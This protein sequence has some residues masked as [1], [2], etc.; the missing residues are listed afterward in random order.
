[1][2]P[3][4]GISPGVTMADVAK[5]SGVSLS[6]VSLVINQKPGISPET[7]N[8][9][10]SAAQSLGYQRKNISSDHKRDQSP[11]IQKLGV[12]VKSQI[13]DPIPPT[14]NVFY[15]HVLAGIEES[16][17]H[18]NLMLMLSSVRVDS[19]SFPLD[20]P[21]LLLNDFIDA[22]LLVGICIN[23]M[24]DAALGQTSLPTVLVDANS[25]SHKYDSVVIRN[26]EAGYQIANY[27][28][29]QGHRHIA[30]VGGFESSH[31]SLVDRRHGYL[32][33][34]RDKGISKHYIGDCSYNDPQAVLETLRR[35]RQEAP[36][37]SAFM[38]CNDKVAI[39][40]IQSANELGISVPD[41][42]SIVG[43]DNIILSD[44]IAPPL[45]TMNVD[46]VSLGRLGVEL[47]LYRLRY[48]EAAVIQAS[49][50]TTLIERKS[51]CRL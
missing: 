5:L 25:C 35:M 14:S 6:T 12:F 1:M 7:R 51:V 31:P 47:L 45:T 20:I 9:V 41:E 16:C 39:E 2:V 28:I 50:S 40:L 27:L 19:H 32:Q 38:A 33:A 34:L 46:K 15:S 42:I 11:Q 36:E 21:L 23:E 17:R 48:P 29:D 10:L 30:F 26:F 22:V 43:F 24:L 3:M 8:K 13:D 37:I 49:T 4:S 44:K 18:H